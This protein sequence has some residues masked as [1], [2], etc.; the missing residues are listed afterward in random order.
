MFV[1]LVLSLRCLLPVVVVVVV[2]VVLCLLFIVICCLLAC[3]LGITRV[4]YFGELLV[5]FLLLF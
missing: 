3:L 5:I 2:C 4:T 1:L